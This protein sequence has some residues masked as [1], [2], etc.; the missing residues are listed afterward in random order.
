MNQTATSE[1]ATARRPGGAASSAISTDGLTKRYGAVTALEDL[2]IDVPHGSVFGFLGPN[3]A[4]KSTAMKL[5]AGLARPTSGG[6][7]VNGIPVT[8]QG[9]HRRELGYL[10]Q[11][12]RFYGWMTGREVLRYVGRFHGGAS[13]TRINELL[14][15]VGSCWKRPTVRPGATRGACASGSASPRRSSGSPRSSC[16]TSRPRRSTRSGGRR[17][18]DLI[19]DLKGETTVFYSTH[20]LDDVQRVSDHVA[21]LHKGRLVR[22]ARTKDLLAGSARGTLRVVLASDTTGS[23]EDLGAKLGRHA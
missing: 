4:G 22:S 15:R 5:L 19:R 11:D 7:R 2:S 21:V 3:G 9:N 13:E 8:P 6:A 16:S 18:L 12:P 1:T 14:G 23:R 17:C 10:A 20:I